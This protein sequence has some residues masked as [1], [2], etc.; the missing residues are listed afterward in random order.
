MYKRDDPEIVKEKGRRAGFY[1]GRNSSLRHHIASFHYKEYSRLCKEAG[2]KESA[3]AIP[4]DIKEA[5]EAAAK[6]AA[7]KKGGQRTLDGV[8]KKVQ[9]PMAF[10]SQEL[11]HRVT[12]H[13][14]CCDEVRNFPSLSSVAANL[15][16]NIPISQPLAVADAVTFRN[17]LV[18]MRPKTVKSDLP[19]YS[20]VRSHITNCFVD[21]MNQ[22]KADIARALGNVNGMCDTW[23]APHTSDSM[24]SLLVVWIDIRP[25]RTWAYRDEV[26]AFHKIL[27]DHGGRN[28]GRYLILFL[29]RCGVTSWEHSKVSG[30]TV[31]ALLQFH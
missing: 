5:R 8:V 11:L 15:E 9:M 6:G 7:G 3:Q 31:V 4:E 21:F 22:L 24:F 16:F 19:T 18:T 14:M 26:A 27:G 13:I 17:V 30:C 10:S 20:L 28:L 1:R 12:Q 23:T 25:D 29:D 2:V